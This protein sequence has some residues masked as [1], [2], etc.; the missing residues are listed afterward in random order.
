MTASQAT[1]S[2]AVELGAEGPDECVCAVCD[3]VTLRQETRRVDDSDWKYMDQM[4]KY[5]KVSQR[6]KIPDK[7]TAQ[8]RSPS[9]LPGLD[10]M[11]VSPRGIHC[12]M[13]DRKM[14]RAWFLICCEC[15]GSIKECKLPKFSIANGFYVGR[16]DQHLQNLTL[17][18]RLMT[19]LSSVVASTRV[20]RGGR[21]RLWW[22]TISWNV[23]DDDDQLDEGMNKEQENVR[24]ANDDVPVVEEKDESKIIER[25]MG[26]G[27]ADALTTAV[28]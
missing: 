2:S 28:V 15:D 23:D 1:S 10:G 5:V 27:L 21:H 18:E 20:M 4:K 16:L 25:R 19:Q 17:S 24:G 8:Y 3:R 6:V 7:I 22:S 12:Y 14:P 9:H 11:L 26:M 13:D